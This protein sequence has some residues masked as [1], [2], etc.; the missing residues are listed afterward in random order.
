LEPLESQSLKQ[1]FVNQVIE[2]ILTGAI[3]TGE[4]MPSERE[5]AERMQISRNVVRVGLAELC[6][7]GFLRV[8]PRRGA[9]VS[10]FL[11][12]GNILMLDAISA[13]ELHIPPKVFQNILE[14]RMMTL[15]PSAAKCA[16]KRTDADLAR[17]RAILDEQ[18]GLSDEQH[19]EFARLDFAYHKEIYIVSGNAF[20]PMFLN[21]IIQLHREMATA[22][23]EALPGKAPVKT[24]HKQIYGAIE[25]RDQE[26]AERATREVLELGN[27]VMAQ[28]S[29]LP[30]Q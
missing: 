27:T 23:Y 24:L 17:M 14:L 7:L 6:A 26:T 21:S 19:G 10:D 25:N 5:I 15:C 1:L 11:R 28:L 18:A 16:K 29:Y 3:R 22:F 2:Q 9:Y 8:E 13:M 12:D 30:K 4:R 20:Y